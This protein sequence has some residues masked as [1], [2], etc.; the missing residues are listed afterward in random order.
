MFRRNKNFVDEEVYSD[1]GYP[2]A[3]KIQG[4]MDQADIL[5]NFFPN[6]PEL[7]MEQRKLLQTT[8]PVGAEGWFVLPMWE[9]TAHTY[10]EAVQKVLAMIASKRRFQISCGDKFTA[11]HLRRFPKT[12]KMM[13]RISERQNPPFGGSVIIASCQFGLR[14]RGRSVRRARE[15]F[16]ENEF[17]LGAFEVAC[18]LLTHPEREMYWEHLQIECAGDECFRDDKSQFSDVPI[19]NSFLSELHFEM[20]WFGW[21]GGRNCGSA[22][23]FLSLGAGL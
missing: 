5:R 8:L 9:K 18:M 4:L 22:T 7:G 16:L 3:Y 17:G 23:G 12:A 6:I 14:H 2:E 20:D 1:I 10:G 15:V 13:Q 21:R 19:F 11:K